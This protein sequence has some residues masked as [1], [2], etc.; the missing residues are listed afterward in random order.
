MWARE[1]EDSSRA[2]GLF[3]RGEGEIPVTARWTDLGISGK[4]TV[5]DIW[6]QKN[7]GTFEKQFQV[8]VPRHGVVL[9]RLF[10]TQ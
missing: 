4:Q 7:L 3:N 1:M 2:V 6:R 9:V 5:R 8:S 10:P